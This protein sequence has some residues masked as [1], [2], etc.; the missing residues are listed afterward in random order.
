MSGRTINDELTPISQLGQSLSF[1][2]ED[3]RTNRSG[4]VT[5]RQRRRLWKRFWSGAVIFLMLLMV[6]IIVSWILVA[7]GTEGGLT[8]IITNDAATIGYL[9]G[10]MACMFYAITASHSFFLAA[11]LMRGEVKA[12]T[13]PVERYGH[14]LYIGKSRYLL[15]SGT[16]DL[17]QSELHYTLYV[18]PVSQ[19]ILSLE[20]AE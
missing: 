12:I 13:G 6:P 20:F 10:A 19:M 14:Y 2:I 8:D 1:S 7:W 18:L 15:Q 4:N 9:T 3:L 11:D 17:V 16:L 5:V